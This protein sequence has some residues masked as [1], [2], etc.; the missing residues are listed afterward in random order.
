MPL[1][2]CAWCVP[3]LLCP[4]ALCLCVL[5]R[6]VS[7]FWQRPQIDTTRPACTSLSDA[8]TDGS[9]GGFG[10]QCGRET[11]QTARRETTAKKGRWPAF[12]PAAARLTPPHPLPSESTSPRARLTV[13]AAARTVSPPSIVSLAARHPPSVLALLPFEFFPSSRR[14]PRGRRA[15]PPLRC[16][17]P[18]HTCRRRAFHTTPSVSTATQRPRPE[19]PPVPP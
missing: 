5:P 13:H 7:G 17:V 14:P 11:R 2:A 12:S 9:G 3:V 15:R 19:H 16:P 18:V 4:C 1:L 8:E 6:G 10:S